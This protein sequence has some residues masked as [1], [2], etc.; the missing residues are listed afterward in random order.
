[1][2]LKPFIF[3][4]IEFIALKRALMRALFNACLYLSVVDIHCYFKAET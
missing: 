2:A 1:M 3:K 4:V